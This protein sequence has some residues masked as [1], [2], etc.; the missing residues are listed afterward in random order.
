MNTK[1]V[2]MANQKFLSKEYLEAKYLYLKCNENYNK[3]LFDANIYLCEK[4]LKEEDSFDYFNLE[5][6]YLDSRYF[7]GVI[8]DNSSIKHKELVSIIIT[9]CNKYQYIERAVNS[10]LSQ[11]KV[12]VEILVVDDGST[13]GSV[14]LL[15]EIKKINKRKS[16]KIIS[17]LRN[18][19]LFYARNIG[20]ES[21]NGEFVTFLD[22]DD[23]MAP[24]FVSTQ[25]SYLK[26][27]KGAV[28]IKCKE[29]YWNLDYSKALSGVSPVERSLLWETRIVKKVGYYDSVRF[30][31]SRE[32]RC[33]VQ[34]HFGTDAIIE[35]GEELYFSRVVSD[36]SL[37]TNT[38][39]KLYQI[40][41]DK[42]IEKLSKSRVKYRNNFNNWQDG[43]E[44]LFIDF[45]LRKR[46]F[47]LGSKSQ[48]AS[49][50]INQRV[51][52]AIASFPPREKSLKTTISCIL[53]QIDEL[54]VYLNN[55]SRT[56]GFLK[57][58]K[59]KVFR[60]EDANGDLRD[61]GKFY[62]LSDDDAY[63]FTFD[64]DII[65]P[66]NYVSTM[67]H[68]IEVLNRSSVV[69]VHGVIF[70]SCRLSRLKERKV[71]H[72]S[73]SQQGCFVDLL[74][75]GTTAWHS[76]L[77]KPSLEDFKETG[78][79]DLWFS[80][81]VN[82]LKIPMFSVPREENWI[83]EPVSNQ[84]SLWR[85][86]SKKPDRFLNNYNNYLK[87]VLDKCKNRLKMES[88]LLNSYPPEVLEFSGIGLNCFR[89]NANPYRK[90]YIEIGGADGS[91]LSFMKPF[92]HF[93]IVVNGWNCKR[94][95]DACLRS[96]A[97]QELGDYTFEVILVDDGSDDGTF[98]KL[99]SSTILPHSSI[100]C[101]QK[102]TGPAFARH[103]GIKSISDPD[104]IIVLVDLDDA[105][106]RNALKKVSE[107]YKTNPNCMMT[108]G[109]W[110]DQNGVINPQGFYTNEEIDMKI[111]RRVEEFNATHLRTF[112]RK[113]YNIID[114]EDLQD[115]NGH[116]LRYCTD[117]ALMYPL[118]DACN[119]SQISFI[120][121]PIYK[122]TRGHSNGT[123]SRY[124]RPNKIKIL[125]YIKKKEVKKTA[126]N[127]M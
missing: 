107:V 76:S 94:Y 98:E 100:I 105:L 49:R 85:E 101:V 62:N 53:P 61:N 15:S 11:N 126:N 22:A 102:N 67:V 38:S 39:S 56:P 60:S 90:G 42:I 119:A 88:H 78:S 117:V 12:N 45:P 123:V 18:F 37:S 27:N 7:Y 92:C 73:S 63:F 120:K 10:A 6:K 26:E 64:D 108:I 32:F 127:L 114:D 80:L 19:G 1:L 54:R 2:E 43:D 44:Q 83:Y 28:A 89:P 95:V 69:G 40:K 110:I 113:L 5:P 121:E 66:N 75:T 118:M 71:F 112:K 96:I 116:W 72:F 13:D 8:E 34:K 33:R 87:P 70:P 115:E 50:S 57:H 84:V 20:L 109:N 59:I 82:L 23:I 77:F 24:H 51:V 65:Y 124:G 9:S 47:E 93:S 3:S 104:S 125:E 79:C 4:K 86:A 36:E 74:G 52:G 106:E 21:C 25:L 14:S 16:I 41:E 103:A 31:G 35:I 48:N 97:E 29:R 99:M 58:E 30:D 46:S 55:Y 91:D 122:Y 17:L 111:T 68:Y 81:K